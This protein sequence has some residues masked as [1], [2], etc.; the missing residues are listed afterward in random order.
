MK[1]LKHVIQLL[2]KLA[3]EFLKAHHYR[4]L[5]IGSTAPKPDP[6]VLTIPELFEQQKS[7]SALPGSPSTPSAL[8]LRDRGRMM[9]LDSWSRVK[10]ARFDRKEMEGR[11]ITGGTAK[12]IPASKYDTSA[13]LDS[14]TT[15]QP[16]D[17]SGEVVNWINPSSGKTYQLNT[18]TGNTS[19]AGRKRSI[20]SVT[21]D[22][23]PRISIPNKR[24]KSAE[25]SRVPGPFVQNL[26]K[27]PSLNSRL[28]YCA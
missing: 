2:Q 21:P 18:R 6:P 23:H 25:A 24:S 17:S 8:E 28:E 27:V 5:A 10:A 22:R 3:Y 14:P 7:T 12:I 26:L 13:L 11:F 15:Q 20:R 1:N 4:P 19:L 9:D 16:D